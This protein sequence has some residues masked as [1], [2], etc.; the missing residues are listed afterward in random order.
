[1]YIF[2]YFFIFRYT[3]YNLAYNHAYNLVSEIVYGYLI[4]IYSVLF[5]LKPSR[6][7]LKS[8]FVV[9]KLWC[10]KLILILIKHPIQ[11]PL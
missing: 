5:L 8:L 7:E 10:I 1:M 9:H 4:T 3:C 11:S 2:L 6:A